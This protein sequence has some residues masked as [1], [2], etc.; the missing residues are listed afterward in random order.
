MHTCMDTY[1]YHIHTAQK[2]T[3]GGPSRQKSDN[4]IIKW[5]NYC[6]WIEI[7]QMHLNPKVHYDLYKKSIGHL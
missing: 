1:V 3:G 7:Y 4:L 6:K 2:P 5:N